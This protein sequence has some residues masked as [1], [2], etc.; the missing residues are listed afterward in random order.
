MYL[1][2]LSLTDFRSWRTLELAFAEGHHLLVGRNG[3]GKTNILEAIHVLG[4][5]SS[6]RAARDAVLAAHGATRFRVAGRF[7][8]AAGEGAGRRAEVDWD[9]RAGKTI[10]LDKESARAS[11]LLAAVKVVS[12]APSDVE[13]VRESGRVRRRFLDLLGSQLSAEYL[14]LLRDYQRAIRQRNE[15]LTRAFVHTRGRTGAA[16]AR[17][18]WTERV[19]AL[20][21]DLAVRRAHLVQEL[22]AALAELAQDAFPS[23]LGVEYAPDV[24]WDGPDATAALEDALARS[25]G[26]DEALGYTTA[27]PHADD[28]DL[29]LGGKDL[30][31]YGSLGQQ[32]LAAMFLKLAQADMVRRSAVAPPI[33]LVDE[34]FAVLDRPA[35]EEF[36]RRVESE[37]QIFLATAQEGWLGELRSRRFHVHRVEGGQIRAEE[38]AAA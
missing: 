6:M 14:R 7:E 9:A 1:R 35:A 22:A 37:G 13:L 20:G 11:D 10:L 12:F 27:G 36:L 17:E 23:A 28:V 25:A 18:P 29:R 2:H 31:R 3:V 33:L 4:T 30:R 38:T 19:T 34:M 32:Q 8:G 26:K 5:G 16:L 24:P 21:A 15:T